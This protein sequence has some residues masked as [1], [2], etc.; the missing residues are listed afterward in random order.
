MNT[1]QQ[2]RAAARILKARQKCEQVY[3]KYAE[4]NYKMVAAL[5]AHEK[6]EEMEEHLLSE[7]QLKYNE[8]V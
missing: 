2:D 1:K 3:G 8:S 6:A 5:R 7:Y 4:L